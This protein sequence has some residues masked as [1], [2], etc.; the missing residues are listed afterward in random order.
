MYVTKHILSIPIK[1]PIYYVENNNY[2]M[3]Q[4]L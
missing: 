3:T 4:V 1:I 2:K